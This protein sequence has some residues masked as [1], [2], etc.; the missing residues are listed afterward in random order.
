M[1]SWLRLRKRD[2]NWNWSRSLTHITLRTDGTVDCI[3][4]KSGPNALNI[5]TLQST[6]VSSIDIKGS[7][8]KLK[9]CT[10]DLMLDNTLHSTIK[11]PQSDV[12]QRLVGLQPKHINVS[13]VPDLLE[14]KINIA[15]GVLGKVDVKYF[16]YLLQQHD[17]IS[18]AVN[19]SALVIW[20][21]NREFGDNQSLRSLCSHKGQ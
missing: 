13:P 16:D 6:V 11:I 15:V 12:I 2:W 4:A 18:D 10:H 8:D 14:N 3:A 21:E 9:I 17:W 1:Q 20:F 5:S 19:P 7:V